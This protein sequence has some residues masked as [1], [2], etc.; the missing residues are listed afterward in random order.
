[1]LDFGELDYVPDP[2]NTFFPYF[3]NPRR[4]IKEM[5]NIYALVYFAQMMTRAAND[6]A[7]AKNK[8]RMIGYC[9]PGT[10]GSQ[11]YGWT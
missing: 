10:A 2:E 4:S 5:H 9:R 11:R 7:G 6:E 1:M 8:S 3:N